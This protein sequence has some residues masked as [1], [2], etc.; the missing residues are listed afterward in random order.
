[1]YNLFNEKVIIIYKIKRL[2]FKENFINKHKSSTHYIPKK[3]SDHLLFLL[4]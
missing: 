2:I 3:I 4:L 1:M